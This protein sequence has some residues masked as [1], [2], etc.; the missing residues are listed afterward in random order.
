M[1]MAE[2]IE[3]QLGK[4]DKDEEELEEEGESSKKI[5]KRLYVE[6][7]SVKRLP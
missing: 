2:G 6:I 5:T 3:E 4:A 7:L 1:L